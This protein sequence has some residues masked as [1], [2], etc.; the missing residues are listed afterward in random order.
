[1]NKKLLYL[2]LAIDA[3]DTSLGFTS[4]WINEISKMYAEV[5]VVTLRLGEVPNFPPNINIYGPKNKGRFYKY[6]YLFK[7]CLFLTK[8]NNYDRCFSHMSPNSLFVILFILKIRRIKSTLW[9]THPGAK[10]GIKKFIL[11]F[12]YKFVDQIVTA[13]KSSFPYKS[14]KIAVIGHAVDLE[15]FYYN[16]NIDLNRFLILSRISKSKNLEIAINAFL[17]SNFSD[18]KLDIIGGPLNNDDVDYFTELKK[19]FSQYKNINFLDKIDYKKLPNVLKDYSV[20][21]NSA[22]SGFFDKSVLETL[23][24]GMLTFYKNSDFDELIGDYSNFF[25]FIDSHDLE[26]KVND[27]AN[28]SKEEL[29]NMSEI[30]NM[31]LQNHSLRTLNSRIKEY[32]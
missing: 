31:G 10:Y 1:M 30:I 11:F 7:T 26:K 14:K 8:K 27:L 6:L 13:S 3:K 20:S 15:M 19:Q 4:S 25:K 21:F 9:F 5:D 23:S 32:L 17:N 24:S 16:K 29:K 12:V 28:F 18:K 22:G 2:N